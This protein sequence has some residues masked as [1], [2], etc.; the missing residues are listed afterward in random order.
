MTDGRQPVVLEQRTVVQC[1]TVAPGGGLEPPP[2][3]LG[4]LDQRRELGQPALG[5]LAQALERVA[6][7]R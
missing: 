7:A 5:H 1:R 4:A 3:Q 6:V 2:H